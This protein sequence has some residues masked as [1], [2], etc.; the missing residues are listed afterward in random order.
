M[1]AFRFRFQKA[2]GRTW[3]W[4]FLLRFQC[5]CWFYF[6]CLKSHVSPSLNLFVVFQYLKGERIY[7]FIKWFQNDRVGGDVMRRYQETL[8]WLF[9]SISFATNN[10]FS[11]K[12]SKTAFLIN[13]SQFSPFSFSRPTLVN[14]HYSFQRSFPFSLPFLGQERKTINLHIFLLKKANKKEKQKNR[15]ITL[16]NKHVKRV[17]KK[18]FYVLKTQ[19]TAETKGNRRKRNKPLRVSGRR[20][21]EEFC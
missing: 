20:R 15:K 12:H 17:K 8:G 1:F 10:I 13:Q 21:G 11:E 5:W 2:F 7:L 16:S 14:P 19:S 3:L 18:S 9:S 4:P 6:N